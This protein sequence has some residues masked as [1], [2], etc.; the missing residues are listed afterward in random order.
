MFK[1]FF[2]KLQNFCKTIYEFDGFL[3][4]IRF[5]QFLILVLFSFVFIFS[6]DSFFATHVYKNY[7]DHNNSR[8]YLKSDSNY[9]MSFVAQ[10]KV[11][12]SIRFEY[13]VDKSHL[14]TSDRI[15]FS[16]SDINGNTIIERDVY[17][18]SYGRKYINVNLSDVVLDKDETYYIHLDCD[19]MNDSSLLVLY[20]HND[21]SAFDNIEINDAS[22]LAIDTNSAVV[23]QEVLSDK[24]IGLSKVADIGYLYSKIDWINLCLHVLI[25]F[26][27]L[28]IIFIK[29]LIKR[30]WFKEIYRIIAMPLFLYLA[31]EILNV[32]KDRPLNLINP[33]STKH[34]FTLVISLL[35]IIIVYYFIHMLIGNGSIGIAVITLLVAVL[36]FVNHVKM[37]MRGDT[38]MPWDI[39]AAGIAMKTGSTYYFR[40][41]TSFVSGIMMFLIIII[42]I[43][44]TNTPYFRFNSSRITHILVSSGLVV[45]M[46]NGIIMNT[47]L[48]DKMNVYYQV[49]PPYQSYNENG[50]TL[51]FLLHLNNVNADVADPDIF[52][53]TDSLIEEY[54]A[55]VNSDYY[56]NKLNSGDIKPNVICIMSEAYSDL[57][58]IREFDTSEEVMPFYRELMNNS[59]NG[60][61][62]VS[63]FG[64][65]TCNT[66]FEFLTGY[67]MYSLM[68][69]SSAYTFYVNNPIQALPQLFKDNGYKTIGL[70]PFDGN[71]WDR[72]TK[73]PLLGIDDFYTQ[74]DFDSSASYV[75]RYISDYSCFQKIMDLYNSSDEPLFLFCVTMQNHAD[76]SEHYSNMNYDIKI[77]DLKDS[78]GDDYYYAENY[79]SLIRESDDALRYLITELSKSDEPTIVVYFGDHCPTLNDGF[80]NELIQSNVGT[81]TLEESLQMYQTPYFIWANYDLN[82]GTSIDTSFGNH[83]IT[84]PNFLGQTL[85]DLAGIKSPNSRSCLRVLQDY[86]GAISSAS[87]Y[88]IN[89]N[90]Y[91]DNSSISSDCNKVI[92][93]YLSIQYS[94]IYANVDN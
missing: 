80:Y 17:L 40:I 50:T 18:S 36:A 48:L 11:L 89:G 3:Y 26:G 30:N 65:G 67:S 70:H 61:L 71:W 13:D 4:R 88:D 69:G 79:V 22:E 59:I 83:G 34:M 5:Y 14:K 8:I 75:R 9:N 53:S 72:S 16:I 2:T 6:F 76:F 47:S 77:N 42:M 54:S 57:Q 90:P 1:K 15:N 84:S 21:F 66:E 12:N 81:A 52:D 32:E 60:N 39:A 43:R 45:V 19:A 27:L 87:I 31:A 91:F 7:A 58:S 82:N 56:A 73:Y 23:E 62:A 35:I 55:I 64:G 94:L 92:E 44:L 25:Y 28:S 78:N 20:S 46:F 68:P 74:N 51:A 63:I 29:R 41:T 24:A 38:L 33:F 10:S 37:V 49:Y 86:I 93:D 85:L